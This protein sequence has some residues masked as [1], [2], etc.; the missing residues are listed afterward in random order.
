MIAGSRFSSDAVFTYRGAS[1]ARSLAAGSL[2]TQRT[3][4][5]LWLVLTDALA[6]ELAFRIAYWIRFDLQV[7]VA[8]EVVGNPADY[9]RLSLLLI[10]VWLAVCTCFGLYDPHAKRGGIIESSRTFNACTVAAMFVILGTFAIPEFVVSRMWLISVWLLSSFLLAANRFLARRLVYMVRRR[11]F[12]LTPTAIVGT[13]EEAASLAAFLSEWDASGVSI[14][15]F[16]ATQGSDGPSPHGLPTLGSL[17]DVTSIVRDQGVEDVI[18]AITAITRDELLAL[19]E[20][21]DTLPVQLRLSSGVYEL[22]TTRVTVHTL[23]TV[24]LMS[25]HKNRLE[26]SELV[27]KTVLEYS[28]ALAALCLLSPLLLVAAVLISVDSPGGV[29]Y[30]RRVL[31]AGGREFDAF[32][33]RTMCVGGESLLAASPDAAAELRLREKVKGDPRVTRIGRWLRKFSLDEVPQLLN[34]LMGQMSLVGP[35]M[36]TAAEA[37]RYGHHRIN[38]FAVKPGITGLWQV[39]GRSDLSYEQRVTIDMY[40]VRNY[41]VWMDLQ[42]LFIQTLP[43][44]LK[45]R[46]A[47]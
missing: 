15:G 14:S 47:Y 44:V 2:T 37:E 17:A 35:R 7:T 38:L 34:V 5:A 22:L 21:V 23:G 18:V 11:G 45:G 29:F 43:A 41:S 8:P 16:I 26:R 13:N 39:S 42:I 30:R 4:L 27:V 33:L 19:Y 40:Y 20:Q 46:G 36:I 31:G 9:Q 1:P 25:V 24:P 12:L 32:K 10:P 6:L 28:I 3:A